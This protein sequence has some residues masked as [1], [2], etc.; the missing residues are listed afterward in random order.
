MKDYSKELRDY[1]SNCS[2]EHIFPDPRIHLIFK[3][4][5]GNYKLKLEQFN[6]QIPES[7][8]DFEVRYP[9]TSDK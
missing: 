6:N 7:L 9:K 8:K 3:K 2:K 4:M 1:S 5:F